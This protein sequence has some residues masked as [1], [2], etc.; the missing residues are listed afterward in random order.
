MILLR[1]V[2]EMRNLLKNLENY[3]NFSDLDLV[4]ANSVR[5]AVPHHY[6]LVVYLI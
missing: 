3:V 4:S 1:N 6:E 2:S 5:G